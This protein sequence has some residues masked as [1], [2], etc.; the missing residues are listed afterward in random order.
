[1]ASKRY[2]SETGVPKIGVVVPPTDMFYDHDRQL[3]IYRD[4]KSADLLTASA[5]RSSCSGM[6]KLRLNRSGGNAD[7]TQRMITPAAWESIL[8]HPSDNAYDPYSLTVWLNGT[9]QN[10]HTKLLNY[11]AYNPA[12]EAKYLTSDYVFY[13]K[14]NLCEPSCPG[15]MAVGAVYHNPEYAGYESY[16]STGYVFGSARCHVDLNSP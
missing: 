3:L 8:A 4:V 6:A 2:I 5:A 14:T 11:A 12:D 15:D 10:I 13:Q 7:F 1:M 9:T 16:I